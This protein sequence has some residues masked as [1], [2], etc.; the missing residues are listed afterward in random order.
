MLSLRAQVPVVPY[1]LAV[2]VTLTMACVF[3]PK[4]DYR[5]FVIYFSAFA[6]FNGLRAG[7]DELGIPVQYGYTIS[8]DSSIFGTV[9]TTWLQDHFFDAS[10]FS[11]QDWLALGIYSSYFWLT[12]C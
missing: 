2:T 8:F 1:T 12:S 10:Q 7:V 9:P 3:M 4:C 5:L 11:T 6:V